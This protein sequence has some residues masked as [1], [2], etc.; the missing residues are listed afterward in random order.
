MLI[1]GM[2]CSFKS[3]FGS[4]HCLVPFSASLCDK[5]SL[6]F[7]GYFLLL[8]CPWNIFRGMNYLHENKPEP[9]IH[10]DLEPS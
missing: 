2:I 6:T 1:M 7:V 8:H 5:D 4:K 10:R 3:L 9:I